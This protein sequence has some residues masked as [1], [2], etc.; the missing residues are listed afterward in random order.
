MSVKTI[1]LNWL[2]SKHACGE[3]VE[4]FTSQK[5]TDSKILIKKLI[6]IN[7]LNWANWLLVR[8]LDDKIKQVKYAVF[9]AE[10]VLYIYEDRYP[11]DDRP[12]KAIQAAKRYLECSIKEGAD[13][14]DA[15]DA[16]AA[17]AYADADA[18]AAAA[19]ADAADAAAAAAYAD[20]ADAAAAAADAAYADAA[21]AAYAAYAAA[22]YAA[23][24]DAAA[25]AAYVD[26]AAAAYADAADAA[27]A[28]A[29]AKLS[30]K[31]LK[32]GITL[33]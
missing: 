19:Y 5:C 26:A 16:A 6:K 27:A 32:Y 31:I 1:S 14:A 12:R 23:A 18:A 9:A 7:R 11:K 28:D 3:G 2:K 24:A 15:A 25:D 10:Q 21:Y 30:I 4:A 29:A 17:A 22:A 20:A 33:I 13:A 8:V